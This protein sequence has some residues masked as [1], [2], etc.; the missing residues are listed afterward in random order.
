[1]AHSDGGD[2]TRDGNLGVGLPGALERPIEPDR[3][4]GIT[5]TGLFSTKRIEPSSDFLNEQEQNVLVPS[6]Q[7]EG[8]A[9]RD[10]SESTKPLRLPVTPRMERIIREA[11]YDDPKTGAKAQWNAASLA[12]AVGLQRG[13]IIRIIG[14]DDAQ[15]EDSSRGSDRLPAICRALGY[16]ESYCLPLT[17]E[18]IEMVRALDYVRRA[19][20]DVAEFIASVKGFARVEAA[21][22]LDEPKK[23]TNIPQ[24]KGK[25]RPAHVKARSS[26]EGRE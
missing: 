26:G 10:V 21:K 14:E 6:G 11:I 19:G 1:M 20:G 17:D 3:G 5:H 9:T 8:M 13:Q 7:H 15:S 24:P 16:P 18:E 23:P 22:V 12:R 4:D 2:L 25:P